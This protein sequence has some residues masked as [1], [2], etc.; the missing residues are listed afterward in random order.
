[1][2]PEPIGKRLVLMYDS[3]CKSNPRQPS[4]LD[5]VLFHGYEFGDRDM[6][7]PSALSSWYTN[8]NFKSICWPVEWLP[9]EIGFPIRVFC[10]KYSESLYKPTSCP[11]NQKFNDLAEQI[12]VDLIE[13]LPTKPLLFIGH[14]LGGLLIK[15]VLNNEQGGMHNLKDRLK[16]IVFYGV[17]YLPMDPGSKRKDDFSLSELEQALNQENGHLSVVEKSE[18]EFMLARDLMKELH[19]SFCK[20]FKSKILSFKEGTKTHGFVSSPC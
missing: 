8:P 19:K 18:M 3:N 7:Y 16:G 9:G 4:E 14:G 17:P 2:T 13:K 5:V 1:M 12:R 15:S 6:K 20:T 10:I 11:K